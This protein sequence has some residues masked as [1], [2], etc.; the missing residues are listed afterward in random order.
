MA[1][2]STFKP[3]LSTLHKNFH[4]NQ[5]RSFRMASRMWHQ[6]KEKK[7]LERI[8]RAWRYQTG[9]S[10]HRKEPRST[11]PCQINA[12]F[13]LGKVRTTPPLNPTHH[14]HNTLWILS[15]HQ[16]QSTSHTL[17]QNCQRTCG[18]SLPLLSRSMRSNSNIFLACFTTSYARLKLYNALDILKER[19]LYMDTDSVIYTQ[20]PTE[21]SIPIGNYLGQFSNELDEVYHIVEFVAAGPKHHAYNTFKGKQC[22]KVRGFT[23]N[24]WGQKILHFNSVKDL[25]L[26]E[27]LQP[28]DDDDQH[29]LTLHNPHKITRC[30]STKTIKTVSQDKTYKLVLDK[31]VIDHDTFQSFPYSYKCISTPRN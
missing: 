17:N 8:Q 24:D 23:L 16:G 3:T 10:A 7:L 20:K 30:S 28:E 9:L 29:T 15:N 31:R 14:M 18:R 2:Q 6:W 21:S 25:V 1:L 27:I 5:T 12:Q 19:V 26:Y 22:C 11:F 13:L 4:E